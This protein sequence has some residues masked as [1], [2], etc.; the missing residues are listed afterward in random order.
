M[1]KESEFG[2]WL[3]ICKAEKNWRTRTL[4]AK[5][6]KCAKMQFDSAQICSPTF[7]SLLLHLFLLHLANR[8]STISETPTRH[9]RPEVPGTST[10]WM[11]SLLR[12]QKPYRTQLLA[13]SIPLLSIRIEAIRNSRRRQSRL[14]HGVSTRALPT[15]VDHLQ[16][17]TL[18]QSTILLKVATF[19][20]HT[21]RP[22][23]P[24]NEYMAGTG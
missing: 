10:R 18:R 12:R 20:W 15:I 4:F 7:F 6:A 11:A 19:W 1:V 5:S 22:T 2:V 23:M 8:T 14:G 3:G 24:C 17:L 16:L 13:S 21:P 9:C